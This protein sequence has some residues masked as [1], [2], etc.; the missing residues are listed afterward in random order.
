VEYTSQFADMFGKRRDFVNKNIAAI[1]GQ[2]RQI[3]LI[4]RAVDGHK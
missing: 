4:F 3:S 1:L 2:K